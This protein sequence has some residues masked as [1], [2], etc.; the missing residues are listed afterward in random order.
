MGSYV[1][2]ATLHE[3]RMNGARLGELLA[4]Q[5]TANRLAAIQIVAEHFDDDD[6]LAAA[7]RKIARE[8][9]AEALGVPEKARPLAPVL[10]LPDP[11]EP[12]ESPAEALDAVRADRDAW[13]A[14]AAA[15]ADA[16]YD[17]RADRDETEGY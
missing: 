17:A 15:E 4:A 14:R 7:A 2:D 6:E 13:L 11:V 12:T 8:T 16:A 9:V 1:E 5:R 3:V 10:N